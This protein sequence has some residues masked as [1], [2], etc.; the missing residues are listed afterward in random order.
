MTRIR[1]LDG[2]PIEEPELDEAGRAKQKALAD[3]V[4][5]AYAKTGTLTGVDVR[6]SVSR[7]EAEI[8][9]HVLEPAE[10]Q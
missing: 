3:L 5:E 6:E 8:G 9:A 10:R 2:L 7:Y 4:V 1:K